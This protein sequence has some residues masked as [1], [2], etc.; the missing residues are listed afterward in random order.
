[1][2]EVG[3]W[4]TSSAKPIRPSDITLPPTTQIDISWLAGG[5]A[6]PSDGESVAG[7][8]GSVLADRYL[9]TPR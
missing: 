6:P 5:D 2:T 9:Q 7:V 3:R 4:T 1:M 8:F